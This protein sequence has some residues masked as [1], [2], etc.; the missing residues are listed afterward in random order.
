[1]SRKRARPTQ[2]V[3]T[4]LLLACRRRCC[5]CT[6]LNNYDGPKK[7]QIAH[8]NRDRSD[9]RFDNLV[10][11]CL[12]HHD[13][14]DGKTSQAKGLM[15]GEVK[16]Y[17]DKLHAQFPD[18]E[19]S[20][21]IPVTASPEET[22]YSEIRRK[23]PELEFTTRPW[24][25]PLWQIPDEPELFAYKA[26]NGADSV[27]LIE[28][29]DLPDGRIVVVCIQPAGSPG[30]SITNAVEE[31]AFQVCERFELPAE[32]LVWLEHYDQFEPQEWRM[33]TFTQSPPSGP[34]EGPNWTTMT[35]DMWRRLALRP[36]KKLNTWLGRFDSKVT[37]DFE[38]PPSDNIF[39]EL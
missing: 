36:R 23:Y 1:M 11:L 21:S 16:A 31:I 39:G 8:L 38:W 6:F 33:V 18:P 13:E 28:R 10:Y 19:N 2:N 15:P 14:Y 3:Q 34:F 25:F 22:P 32:R 4:Q 37:K 7:G 9:S 24:R 20:L 17:R 30:Q 29:I 35:T 27:C 26:G 12:E 5:L